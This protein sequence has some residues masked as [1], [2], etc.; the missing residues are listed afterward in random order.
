MGAPTGMLI[1]S[2][3][4][5]SLVRL[6]RTYCLFNTSSLADLLQ[7]W[8]DTFDGFMRAD[9]ST[10]CASLKRTYMSA[11]GTEDMFSKS[12]DDVLAL[13]RDYESLQ[14][15]TPEDEEEGYGSEF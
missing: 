3:R 10:H 13:I 4:H 9:T 12:V 2:Y 8:T 5:Q 11:F 7:G 6:N 1:G 14:A 15:Y